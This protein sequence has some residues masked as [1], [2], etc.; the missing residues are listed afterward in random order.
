[1][2][3]PIQ[4]PSRPETLE[5][6]MLQALAMEREA[7][8]RYSELADMMQAHNNRDVAELFHKMAGYEQH[9]VD[10]ILKDM[11]WPADKATPRYAGVWTAPD[12]PEVVPIEE[13]HYLMQPWHALQLALAAEQRAHDFFDALV[14]NAANDTIRRAA[15]E[16]RAEEAEHIELVRAWMEK[17][18]QPDSDWAAD[19][20]PP[21]YI[22]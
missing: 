18:P 15:E 16:M 12:G 2:N 17:V 20:D 1:M 8:E 6:L 3:P 9:H 14:R 5:E 7:V 4:T 21:R 13:M 22:D 11:S 10:H 19:P